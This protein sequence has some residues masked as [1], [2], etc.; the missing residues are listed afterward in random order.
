ML[1]GQALVEVA[2]FEGI[3]MSLTRKISL[4]AK[5]TVS[6]LRRTIR[7]GGDTFSIN[8][9]YQNPMLRYSYRARN[10][11]PGMDEVL[12]TCFKLRQGA[13][14]D[15]GANIGQTFLKV[16]ELDKKR[17]YVGFEPQL[18]GSFLIDDFIAK[19]K[20]SNKI[21]LPIALS[22]KTSIVKLGVNKDNDVVA[23]FV[24]EYR[25]QG[26]YSNYKFIVTMKGDD[27]VAALET[28]V[29]VIKIDV[30]GAEL[31][32]IRGMA[33]TISQY[34][35]C[36]LFEVLPHFLT[37]PKQ[38]I[39]D[40]TKAARDRRHSEIERELRA[41]GYALFQIRPEGVEECQKIKAAARIKFDYL[42]IDPYDAPMFA[43]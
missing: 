41:M 21:I 4:I 10:Y 40:A 19:N 3:S 23:S 28:A 38:E 42:A 11:E 5:L 34:R 15:V 36:I 20:D 12:R 37:I 7:V 9:W 16:L 14:I 26:F 27:V 8:A 1:F 33:K 32:V 29:A 6:T 24:D 39:D 30:E 2:P 25:P 22:D 31:E 18:Y 13:V 17:Q 35:P 43:R